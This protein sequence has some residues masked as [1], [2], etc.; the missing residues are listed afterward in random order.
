MP[1]R[2]GQGRHA[3]PVLGRLSPTCRRVL[4][5]A[6]EGP[7]ASDRHSCLQRGAAAAAHAAEL[8][9][10]VRDRGHGRPSRCSSSTTPA[11]TAPPRSPAPPTRRRMPVRVVAARP[12]ARAPPSAR[13]RGTDA[14]SSP[15]WTPTVPP[16]STRSRRPG[17]GSHWRRRRHRLARRPRGRDRARTAGSASAAPRLPRLHRPRGPRHRRHPVRLQGDPRRPRRARLRR[18]A[19]PGFSFDVE[20]LARA[21]RC[22]ARIDEFPVTWTDVPGSTFVPARHGAGAFGEPGRDRLAHPTRPPHRVRPR[23]SPV[24]RALALLRRWRRRPDMTREPTR[25][26]PAAGSSSSTGATPSTRWPAGP[27]STP[28]SSPGAPRRPAPGRVPHRS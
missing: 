26:W 3:L 12:A 4:L 20:L 22:G 7:D 11:P 18:P 10:Y 13:A 15:S 19:R 24:A 17:A 9:R 21:R 2:A 8:R 27:S 25:P 16:T 28:G 14:A 23:R 1:T 6:W 5:L